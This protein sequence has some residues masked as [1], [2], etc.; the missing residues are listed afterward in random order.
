MKIL[1]V[2]LSSIGDIVHTL[3][4]LAAIRRTLPSAEISWAVERG[5]AEILRNNP[6]LQQLIE[7]DTRA[8]RRKNPFGETILAARQQISELRATGFDVAL[9]FQG[10]LKSASIAK[11]AR[12]KQVYG[13]SKQ[14]LREPSSRFLLTDTFEAEKQIHIIDKNLT[15][16]EKALNIEVS[17]ERYEF[18]I[19]TN[20]EHK[21]EAEKIIEQTGTRFAIL[22]P[23]GGWATKLW[24]AEKFGALADRLWEE[25]N[26]TS[27]VTTAPNEI[28]LAEKVLQ[29]SKSNRVLLAQPSLKGF[30]ELARHAKIY[31]GGDTAPTHLAVAANAPVV[32]IFGATEWWRNGSPR[33]GDICVERTDISCRTDCHRRT[34]NNWICMDITVETVLRAVQKRLELAES[35]V[36]SRI[37]NINLS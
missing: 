24:H 17:R 34:C 2:K 32:G 22:N 16:A 27:V 4:A 3:P 19:F 7:V 8:L 18:P 25:K 11:L 31:V 13:F 12:A 20:L 1:I 9:D 5:A 26:L 10:L 21:N 36:F 23:A 35:N 6:F 33:A 37:S 30:Y 14:N 28:K 15:L 29:N